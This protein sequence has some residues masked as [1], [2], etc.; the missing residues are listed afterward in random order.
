MNTEN[1]RGKHG[2]NEGVLR[3]I[4][5]I[6]KFIRAIIKRQLQV[7]EC[8]RRKDDIENRTL[9]RHIEVKRNT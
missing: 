3:K 9:T 1:S 2:R 8:V 7:L 6:S 4:R 5:F